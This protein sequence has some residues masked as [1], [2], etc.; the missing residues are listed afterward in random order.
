M[1][2]GTDMATWPRSLQRE[3]S[4]A[5]Y[6]YVYTP[7]ETDHT[8]HHAMHSSEQEHSPEKI[9]KMQSLHL[10]EV[11]A[12]FGGCLSF[13]AC[14]CYNYRQ[15]RPGASNDGITCAHR[16][17][18]KQCW[19]IQEDC[20]SIPPRRHKTIS[21]LCLDTSKTPSDRT[22]PI[23]SRLLQMF[24]ICSYSGM[25]F[26][27]CAVDFVCVIFFRSLID[28]SVSKSGPEPTK[29]NGNAPRPASR[30]LSLDMLCVKPRPLCEQTCLSMSFNCNFSVFERGFHRY[31]EGVCQAQGPPNSCFLH[32]NSSLARPQGRMR[33]KK[34]GRNCLVGSLGFRFFGCQKFL[35]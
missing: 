25:A 15:S 20:F 28:R 24:P 35:E 4:A 13:M 14:R 26:Q 3:A 8:T 22:V 23:L 21:T 33:T 27:I 7:I 19:W 18:S 34:C 1:W 16:P 17:A 30:A 31:F 29:Q 32:S 11:A 2:C 9:I 10:Y 5:G 6:I 12:F